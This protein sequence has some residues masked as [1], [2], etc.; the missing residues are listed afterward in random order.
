MPS[1]NIKTRAH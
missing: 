1:F